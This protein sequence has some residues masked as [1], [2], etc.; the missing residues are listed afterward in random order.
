MGLLDQLAGQ[1]LGSLGSQQQ[2]PAAQG[3][4]MGVVI[5]LINQ[6]G[7][8]QGLLQKLQASGLG[9]QVASWIST[10]EN[11]PVSGNQIADALG[12]DQLAQAAQQAGVP[13]E[14]ASAGLAQFLPQIIDQL[15]PGGVVPQDDLVAQGLG[16]L[17]GKLFG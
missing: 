5:G 15:T 12:G 11:Q 8:L 10:G 17:K 1:V 6:A 3:G 16:L 9:D 7:G 13:P 14:Q 4:L 2:D